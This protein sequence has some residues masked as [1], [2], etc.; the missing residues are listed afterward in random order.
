MPTSMPGKPKLLILTSTFP[1]WP[2]DIEPG[3]VLDLATRLRD[4]YSVL[5]LAPHGPH[6]KRREHI[7][8]VEVVRFRYWFDRWERLAYEG[9]ILAA[10]KT[11]RWTALLLPFFLL[12][13]L[14]E[15]VRLL[16][17][18][19]VCLIHAHWLLPQGL[20]AFMARWLAGR[21]VPI[22]CTSH[23]GDLFALRDR[24]SVALKRW[25]LGRTDGLTVVSHAMKEEA[26][27]L[28]RRLPVVEVIPMGIDFRGS[29]TPGSGPPERPTKSILFV[30]RL[31][32]KKGLRFLLEAFA[33]IADERPEW[34]L[35]IVGAGPLRS[36]LE[37]LAARL[38]ITV[39]I[40]FLG[41]LEHRRLPDLYRR[42]GIA[43][44]PFVVGADGDREGFG[45]VVAEALG[46]GCPVV[47]SDLPAVRDIITD[48]KTGLLIP[49]GNVSAL[50]RA[51]QELMADQ[52][53]GRELARAGR[54]HVLERFDWGVVSA[55]Y[56][57]V[58]DA[59]V[60]RRSGQPTLHPEGCEEHEGVMER[61]A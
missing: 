36:E 31:V 53:L 16:R 38:R 4:S 44:F 49:P 9:G 33:Q 47:A 22:L 56:Q 1:R 61:G 48:G 21:R 27:R 60:Q 50:V 40:R 51:I 3:F 28:C 18:E 13:E 20:L 34:V 35:Q 7:C 19:P 45:L 29:F 30:G 2:G 11:R 32:E 12:A 43:V 57:T 54:A 15:A 14:V 58:M 52:R 55:R 24:F 17:R 39:R 37:R 6:M 42:A 41:G 46:C 25:V 23:G 59:L 5:V 26:A 8:G 10:F